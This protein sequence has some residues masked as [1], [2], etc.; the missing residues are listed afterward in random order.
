MYVEVTAIQ[1]F[2][3]EN[4]A[5]PEE[6]PERRLDKQKPSES[7]RVCVCVCVCA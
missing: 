6:T 5:Q 4:P 7:D 1:R 3:V 2:P